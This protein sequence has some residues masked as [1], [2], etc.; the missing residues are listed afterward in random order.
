[1][2]I[3]DVAEADV[4]IEAILLNPVLG[5]KYMSFVRLRRVL[6]A[7][8]LNEARDLDEHG[9]VSVTGRQQWLLNEVLEQVFCHGRR[10]LVDEL[11]DDGARAEM[12]SRLVAPTIV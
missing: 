11:D 2:E 10:C 4:N 12:N 7:W 5:P 8:Y 6:I 9:E 3:G 1:M